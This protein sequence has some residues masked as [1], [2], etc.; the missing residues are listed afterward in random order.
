MAA[1]GGDEVEYITQLKSG[2]LKSSL[3]TKVFKPPSPPALSLDLT[4]KYFWKRDNVV[5]LFSLK[6]DGTVV[7]NLENDGK[8]EDHGKGLIKITRGD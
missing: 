2:Q 6:A 5:E 8:W 1:T 7:F 4:G 3:E